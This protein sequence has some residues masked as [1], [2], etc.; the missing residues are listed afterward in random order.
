MHT[1]RL[2]IKFGQDFL[3]RANKLSGL[4]ARDLSGFTLTQEV[5]H[6]T[7]RITTGDPENAI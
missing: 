1:G 5:G 4:V 3:L 7:D 2:I 6:E